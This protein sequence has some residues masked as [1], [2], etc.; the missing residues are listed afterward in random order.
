MTRMRRR[1]CTWT[2]CATEGKPFCCASKMAIPVGFM[3]RR[4]IQMDELQIQPCT[5]AERHLT[6]ICASQFQVHTDTRQLCLSF[7]LSEHPAR[8]N[9]MHET[10][11]SAC[12]L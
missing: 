7:H 2:R 8:G 9:G 6:S 10:D 1:R 12:M 4:V 11:Q 3:P 5:C